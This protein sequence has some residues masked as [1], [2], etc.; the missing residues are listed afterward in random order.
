M[1]RKKIAASTFNDVLDRIIEGESLRDIFKRN[2]KKQYPSLRTFCRWLREDDATWRQ[3]ARAK[4]IMAE[5]M[6]SEILEIADDTQADSYVDDNGNI[7]IDH[8]NINR[9]RLRVDTRKWLA[10][11]L[12]PKLYGDGLMAGEDQSYETVDFNFTLVKEDEIKKG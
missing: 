6:A 12:M 5:L 9:S 2:P 11:K 7:K 8:E 10:S 1:A 3:Y 4:A